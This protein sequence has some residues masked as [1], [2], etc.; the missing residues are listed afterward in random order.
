M[1]QVGQ[2]ENKPISDSITIELK[3]YAADPTRWHAAA[4]LFTVIVY[5]QARDKTVKTIWPGDPCPK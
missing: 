2:P 3:D 5:V 1:P 4:E